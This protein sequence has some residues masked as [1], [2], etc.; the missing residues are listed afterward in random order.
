MESFHIKPFKIPLKKTK[1]KY[2]SFPLLL[3]VSYAYFNGEYY[4]ENTDV[5]ISSSLS[6]PGVG[7]IIIMTFLLSLSFGWRSLSSLASAL[8]AEGSPSDF[9]LLSVFCNPFPAALTG[10]LTPETFPCWWEWRSIELSS[11]TLFQRKC[12]EKMFP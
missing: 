8:I 6:Y 1:S 10:E 12:H 7:D 4:V 5:Y 2:L 11:S 9:L 3:S